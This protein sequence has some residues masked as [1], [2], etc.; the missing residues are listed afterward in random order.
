MGSKGF[1]PRS[2]DLSSRIRKFVYES[3]LNLAIVKRD[4]RGTGKILFL[5]DGSTISLEGL[6]TAMAF[7]RLTGKQL[8]VLH[9][10]NEDQRANC[11]FVK[12]QLKAVQEANKDCKF[13]QM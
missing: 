5:L 1:K 10:F 8:T 2:N 4:D 6:Q 12:N 9:A 7:S 3:K 11:K 13:E